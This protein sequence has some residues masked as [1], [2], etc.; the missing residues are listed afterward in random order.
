MTPMTTFL[1]HGLVWWTGMVGGFFFLFLI[2]TAWVK[3][4]NYNLF[5]KFQVPFTSYHHWF[6][7]L[8]FGIL[9]VHF[10]LALFSSVFFVFF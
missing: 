6:G 2:I 1:Q 7:W 3:Q 5:M 9:L 8:C 4:Y 10:I